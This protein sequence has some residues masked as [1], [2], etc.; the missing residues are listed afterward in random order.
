[1]DNDCKLSSQLLLQTLSVD[2]NS[3]SKM[4][5]DPPQPH[6]SVFDFYM[7]YETFHF[8]KF[9]REEITGVHDVNVHSV[10]I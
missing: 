8:F 7:V 2:P 10:I 9:Q 1:M 3:S 4:M 5:P 6:A